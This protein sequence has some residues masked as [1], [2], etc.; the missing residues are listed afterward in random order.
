MLS[1]WHWYGTEESYDGGNVKISTDGGTNWSLIT[2]AGGYD[3]S[4]ST[5][6]ENPIG[7]EMAFTG[8]G[9]TWG[10]ETFDLSMYDGESIMIRFDFGSD[11]SV[12]IGDGWY[13]D[14]VTLEFLTT[15]IENGAGILPSEFGL[16]QNY[17]NPFNA[18]TTIRYNLSFAADV[19]ISVFDL[20]GRKIATL[21][22]EKQ[23]AGSHQITWNA[24]DISSGIY[25]YKIEAGGFTDSRKMLLLK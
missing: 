6:Y 24:V 19:I 12:V 13:I 7:G 3:F 21:V 17:P 25:F 14:D 20:L 5:E 16:E 9:M 15:G 1:F 2:P 11:N 8:S 23:Q 4:L 10:Q 18:Q 22:E